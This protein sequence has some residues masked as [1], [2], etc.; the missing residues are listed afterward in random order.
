MSQQILHSEPT[1]NVSEESHRHIKKN[2]KYPN[3]AAD[4]QLFW[5]IQIRILLLNFI[6]YGS[7]FSSIIFFIFLR[8]GKIKKIDSRLGRAIFQ[9]KNSGF[10]QFFLKDRTLMKKVWKGAER[11]GGLENTLKKIQAQNSNKKDCSRS[12]LV[13][14]KNRLSPNI[15]FSFLKRIIQWKL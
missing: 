11:G 6:S 4:P 9:G 15:T 10:I 12:S 1:M 7:F 2:Y 5:R 14:V 3:Y 13:K 8:S